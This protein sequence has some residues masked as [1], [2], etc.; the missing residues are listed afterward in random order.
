M[1]RIA[2]AALAALTAAAGLGPAQAGSEDVVV[3]N[4]WARAT[5]GTARPGAAYLT[6]RNAGDA[7]LTLT[8]VAAPIAGRAEIHLSSMDDNGVSSM[9][10][11]GEIAVGPSESIPLEPGGLHV[12][13]MD[14]QSSLDEGDAFELMLTFSDGGEVTVPVAVLGITARGPG[15]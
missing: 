7:T 10:P 9:M 12:M 3:E 8:G 2:M 1:N 11:A 15:G 14:L 6:L 4:A 13:L 5:I